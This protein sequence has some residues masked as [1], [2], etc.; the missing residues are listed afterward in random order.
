M[1]AVETPEH[2]GGLHEKNPWRRESKRGEGKQQA[3]EEEEEERR[4]GMPQRQKS[5]GEQD[6]TRGERAREILPASKYKGNH[7]MHP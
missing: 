1:D 2:D 3:G 7:S 5:G 4:G 6:A